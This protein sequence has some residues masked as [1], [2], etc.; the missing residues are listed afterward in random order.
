LA[1]YIATSE[2]I[3][4][5]KAS[6]A[7]DLAVIEWKNKI[8]TTPLQ[9]GSVGILI[10][11]ERGQIIFEPNKTVNYLTASFGLSPVESASIK[12]YQE[13]VKP[14]IP[15]LN[16]EDKKGIPAFIK[17]AA[18]AAILL[19]LSFVGNNLYQQNKK[20]SILA[21][22]EK[23]IEKKIQ[24]ATFIIANPLQTIELN[25]VK[26]IEIVKSFHVVAGAFQFT[27]N[28]EKKVMQLQELGY[29]AKIIGINK[30]G[31]TEVSFESFT[32][33]NDAI[34]SLY[35]IQKSVSADAW[36]LVKK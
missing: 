20:Q 10:L 5:E 31:L 12:R 24:S 33:R 9:I 1:N 28:A 2:N 27:K 26:E 16:T 35:K 11:N 34:N 30:W 18:T 19:T 22:Q 21:N 4:F 36:L 8:Q 32:D 17:Y 23:A 15:V 13:Q 3:S 29:D 25:V 7:I 14:L 6:K